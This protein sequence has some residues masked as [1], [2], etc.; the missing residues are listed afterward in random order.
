MSTMVS[1]PMLNED[2]SML[3]APLM[4][5]TPGE[6]SGGVH[7]AGAREVGQ[8]IFFNRFFFL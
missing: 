8:L 6:T 7:G 5:G 4:G 1:S 2:A 3:R